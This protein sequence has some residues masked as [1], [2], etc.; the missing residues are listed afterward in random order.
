[1]GLILTVQ[2]VNIPQFITN[3]ED[4]TEQHPDLLTKCHPTSS[5]EA[6][7]AN[8]SLTQPANPRQM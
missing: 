8:T 6:V 7:P 5:Q 4:S 2:N 1:M 3:R